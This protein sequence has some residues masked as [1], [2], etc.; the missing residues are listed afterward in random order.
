MGIKR[1]IKHL[2]GILAV[3]SI[4][5]APGCKKKQEVPQEYKDISQ[6]VAE[7]DKLSQ[8]QNITG[9]EQSR[10]L[11]E[12]GVND[13]KPNP[14][15]MQLTEEQKKGL[16]ERIKTEKNSSYQALLQE[17]LDKDKEIKDINEKINKLRAVLPKPERAKEGDNHY[18]MSMRYLKKR[19]VRQEEAKRLVSRVNIMEKIAPGFEIYHFYNNGVYGTWVSQGKSK[20]SPNDLVREERERIEGERDTAVAQGEVLK[21]EVDDLLAQKKVI[22][23]E[24]EGLRVERAKLIDDMNA[25]TATNEQQKARLNSIHYLVGDRKKLVKDG[26]II[27]PVF[28]KDRAGKNWSDGVFTQ[29]LDLRSSD[30]ININASDLGM[31]KIGRINV[32][33]GSY[34]K[35][36]H[37]KVEIAQDKGSATVTLLTKDRFKNDKVVFAVTD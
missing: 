34:V 21:G 7:M 35:D 13:V 37:Y 16:E 14:E 18:M 31:A 29:S 8:Q 9:Q 24:I 22:T 1:Y 20:I 15:T 33:P 2:I 23:T 4:I 3:A 11:Q 10:K 17:V 27:V 32:V 5:I 25:L 30:T 26:V 6:K 12:A 28:A 36:E 19:G